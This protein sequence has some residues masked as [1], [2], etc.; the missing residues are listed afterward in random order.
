MVGD[1]KAAGQAGRNYRH[2]L[3]LGSTKAKEVVRMMSSF[4]VISIVLTVIGLVISAFALG[5]SVGRLSKMK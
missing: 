5:V 4:E 3:S 1:R 2:L